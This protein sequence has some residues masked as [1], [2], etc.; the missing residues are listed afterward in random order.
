MIELARAAAL[1][2]GEIIR[3]SEAPTVKHKGRVD[4]VTEVDLACERAIRDLLERESPDIPILGEEGGGPESATTRW[5]VDPLDG[6]TNF[7]H[8]FPFYCVSI[9][10]ESNGVLEHAVVHDAPR[11]RTYHA[12][13]GKG[14]WLEDQRLQVSNCRHLEQALLGSGFSYDRRERADFYLAYLKAFLTRAQGFRRA[15]AAA[16]DLAML[17]SGQ[18][19]GF[20]EF[21]LNAWD[22]A[23]GVLLIEEAGGRVSD[24]DLSPL[25]LQSKRTLASNGFIH[26]EMAAVIAPLL[27][28]PITQAE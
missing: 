6:T 8:G 2:A 7:V 13:R 9:A 25:D 1:L 17:A 19:D 22:M 11:N 21:G 10:L 24:M 15:G 27:G 20:W 5:I 28:S 23:A 26:E 18:L 4:L 16:M 3:S 12:S 14:A